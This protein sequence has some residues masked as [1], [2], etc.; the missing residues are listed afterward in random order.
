MLDQIK[1]FGCFPVLFP[2]RIIEELW[3]HLLWP[4]G[5]VIFVNSQMS[6]FFKNSYR[7]K[8][9]EFF[10]Y[11]LL[12]R[13]LDVN[14]FL[15]SDFFIVNLFL[16]GFFFL[17]YKVGRMARL[18]FNKVYICILKRPQNFTKSPPYFW[19]VLHRTKVRWDFENFCDLLGIY[20]LYHVQQSFQQIS[21][22][23]VIFLG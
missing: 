11:C 17:Q 9:Q 3:C 7:K 10:V 8:P 19:L 20:E 22:S 23:L 15:M 5:K 1:R 2:I 18:V 12:N 21:W 4:I 16:I 6:L 13:A 14:L